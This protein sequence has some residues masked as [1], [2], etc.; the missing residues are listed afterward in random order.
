M[1]PTHAESVTSRAGL[2]SGDASTRSWWRVEGAGCEE[3]RFCQLSIDVSL[4][5]SHSARRLS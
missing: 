1:P 3:T 4:N 5:G 2:I